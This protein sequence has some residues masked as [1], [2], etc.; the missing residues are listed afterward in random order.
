MKLKGYD[1]WHY[2]YYRLENG[3]YFCPLGCNLDHM[4]G[5]VKT[6]HFVAT[7]KQFYLTTEE[8][9]INSVEWPYKKHD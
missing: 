2:C 4:I 3:N 6:N 1:A 9:E 8:S 7:L 5:V